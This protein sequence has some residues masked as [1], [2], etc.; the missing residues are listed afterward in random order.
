MLRRAFTIGVLL[1]GT[2]VGVDAQWLSHRDP[3]IPRTADGRPNLA[4]R[5]P[6]FNGKPDL[7]GVWQAERTSADEYGK[8]LGPGFG[9]LQVDFNDITKHVINV[10]W[11]VKPGEEPFTADGVAAFRQRQG[12]EPGGA[13]CL[14]AGLP[15]NVFVLW[16]KMIHAPG[17][18]VVIPG[19]GDPPRQIYTDGRS[20]PREPEPS[21]TGHS[22]GVWQGDTLV[23]ET[24]GIHPRAAL[25][26]FGHPRSEG[27][28][29]IERYRRRD[30]G[31]MDLEITFDDPKYYTRPF[32]IKTT[33]T[34][35]PDTDVLDY[36]CTENEKDRVHNR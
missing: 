28:R 2:V 21:W 27:M 23:V 19:T 25:D 17:E 12:Q 26:A 30:F 9:Q 35:Q 10:F 8:V 24:V 15:A 13:A 1:V 32:T 16:F 18:I 11:G 31:H 3:T 22:V 33:L 7:S 36:V 20:L 29:I 6:R 5:A 14:P 4:A 34:L